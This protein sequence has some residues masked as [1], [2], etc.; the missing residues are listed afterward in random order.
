[1]AGNGERNLER[2]IN[3]NLSSASNSPFA[4]TPEEIEF[5]TRMLKSRG[6]GRRP[7]VD[8]T[9]QQPR[10]TYACGNRAAP[11]S[12]MVATH[13]GANGNHQNNNSNNALGHNVVIINNQ[14]KTSN[15]MPVT[16]FSEN[17]AHAVI[18]SNQQ[19]NKTSAENLDTLREN[20]KNSQESLKRR[21]SENILKIE[22]AFLHRSQSFG[23]REHILTHATQATA[24]TATDSQMPVKR[25]KSNSVTS[26]S[27]S[28]D[29]FRSLSRSGSIMDAHSAGIELSNNCRKFYF[30]HV[31]SSEAIKQAVRA[32]KHT[33]AREKMEGRKCS[34]LDTA[35]DKLRAEMVIKDLLI[36]FARCCSVLVK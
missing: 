15:T 12:L 29:D 27:L 10:N 20:L 8:K 2:E 18:S 31:Q 3:Q 7:G 17:I 24:I 36:L 33:R 34:P 26:L 23:S 30:R 25:P 28:T 35:M 14:N 16:G 1:M 5:N 21:S 32:A 4:M 19:N 22:E 6:A 11:G 9:D 13:N